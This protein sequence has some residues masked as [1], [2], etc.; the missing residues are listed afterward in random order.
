MPIACEDC[1]EVAVAL[2]V[3]PGAVMVAPASDAWGRSWAL[4]I[5]DDTK[6]MAATAAVNLRSERNLEDFN[7]ESLT[8]SFRGVCGP[9]F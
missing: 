7:R 9:P 6:T 5:P 3:V 1:D 4:A 8:T 2:A